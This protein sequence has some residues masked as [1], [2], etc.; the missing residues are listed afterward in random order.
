MKK[1]SHFSFTIVIVCSLIIF[2]II[3][4]YSE[5]VLKIYLDADRTGTR[6]SGISIEQ[7]IRLALSEINFEIQGYKIELLIKDHRGSSRRSTLHLQEF[8][9]DSDALT[10]FCGLHSPPVLANLNYINDQKILLMDPWAAAGPISR[11]TDSDGNNW[12]FRLS[13]DDTKA[14]EVITAHSVDNEGFRKPILLLEDTGWGRSN[15]ST[16]ITALEERGLEPVDIIWFNWNIGENG[17]RKILNDIYTLD[18]DVIF[19]VANAPEGITF[20]KAMGERDSNVRV[21]IRSHWGITGGN[22]FEM[23]GP[24]LL[25]NEVDLQFIQTSYSFLSNNQTAFSKDIFYRTSSLFPEIH[26]EIDI[27]APC[28]FI[29]AYDLTKILISAINQIRLSENM[30]HNRVLLRMALENLTNSVQGLIKNYSKPFQ[31]YSSD[32]DSA[33]EA[34]GLDDFRMA[35][36]ASDGGIKLMDRI[37]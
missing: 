28:G 37:P 23:L 29:H 13:V 8:V 15:K 6:A 17:A 18:A 16:M 3:P 12:I 36:F 11:S 20:L 32:N 21:P 31:I 1:S 10:V 30:E 19:L 27:E 14:G 26:S 33:H 7:G 25:V 9:N 35:Q 4:V 5:D 22:F 34:L 2:N 24:D